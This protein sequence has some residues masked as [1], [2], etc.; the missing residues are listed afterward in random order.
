MASL[1]LACPFHDIC[2]G[3]IQLHPELNVEHSFEIIHGQECETDLTVCCSLV[4]ECSS[5]NF[6]E[7]VDSDRRFMTF[8]QFY[9][10]NE[11]EPPAPVRP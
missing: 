8:D 4:A 11:S 6:S 10:F 5:C 3:Y 9:N 1:P 2:G 7:V